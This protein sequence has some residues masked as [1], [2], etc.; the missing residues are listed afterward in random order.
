MNK[1]ETLKCNECGWIV[2][3]T[4]QDSNSTCWSCLSGKAEESTITLLD[5]YELKRASN[6]RRIGSILKNRGLA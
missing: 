4:N 1:A 6:I 2:P 5:Y 3:A